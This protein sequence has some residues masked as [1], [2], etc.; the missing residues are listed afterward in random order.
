MP[1][2]VN[3]ALR[4][5]YEID[6]VNL[7]VEP[8]HFASEGIV[9]RRPAALPELVTQAG[10]FSSLAFGV[11]LDDTSTPGLPVMEAEARASALALGATPCTFVSE[12]WLS[13][14]AFAVASLLPGERIKIRR[15]SVSLITEDGS[16]VL[17]RTAGETPMTLALATLGSA[18]PHD[19]IL[20]LIR[21]SCVLYTVAWDLFR[22]LTPVD[23]WRQLADRN[24]DAEIIAEIRSVASDLAS[25][26]HFGQCN[27][28]NHLPGVFEPNEGRAR[29]IGAEIKLE[30]LRN[31]FVE[32]GLLANTYF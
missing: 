11:L 12:T 10:T 23:H 21:P 13:P 16:V 17:F 6:I 31:L 2:D 8:L 29:Q 15:H 4:I 25:T 1:D 22:F 20:T 30:H 32:P 27:L 5:N 9:V 28:L 3:A 14:L 24:I 19:A 7:N 18:P 26:N